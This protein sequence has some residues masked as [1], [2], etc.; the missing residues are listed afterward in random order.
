MYVIETK[1]QGCISLHVTEINDLHRMHCIRH[2]ISCIQHFISCIIS[3]HFMLH[4]A[5]FHVIF[6]TFHYTHHTHCTH[7]THVAHFAFR[8]QRAFHALHHTSRHFMCHFISFSHKISYHTHSYHL[9][10]KRVE[11]GSKRHTLQL[12][13]T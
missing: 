9:G 12:G 10:M 2:V 6:Y 13:A 5:S 3:R 7:V 8:E 1:I 11:I 4:F